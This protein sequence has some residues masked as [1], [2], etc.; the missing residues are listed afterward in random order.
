MKKVIVIVGPTAVGKTKL[1]IEIA[2]YL[3]TEI[4]SGDSAQVYKQLDIGTAKITSDEMQGI[5]HHLIDILEPGDSFSVAE[6]Q[7]IVREKIDLISDDNKIPI[8]VGGTGLYLRSVLYDYKFIE[9][10]RSSQFMASYEGYTNAELH[11][12]LSDIDP[13]SAEMIHMNNRRRVLRAIEIGL[14]SDS[15]KSQ[16]ELDQ[17]AKMMYDACIIGLNV[18][19]PLLY[20]RINARVDDMMDLGLLQE[21]RNLYNAGYLLNII[22][23]KEFQTYFSGLTPLEE[24]IEKLKKDSRNLA[25]RQ[26]TFFKNKFDVNWFT[27]SITNFELT[28]ND[29][30]QLINT[31]SKITL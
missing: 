19:R 28:V 20:D 21:A 30:I 18:D 25:K 31:W 15:K 26:L 11:L 1:S 14:S 5:K 22:G 4:I 6:F 3:Q 23:Y 17:D 8:L 12:L 7:S 27:P 16:S 10:E 13:K 9:R 2:K 24:S 29:V